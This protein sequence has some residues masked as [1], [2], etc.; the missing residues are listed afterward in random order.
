MS[1]S[2][3][4]EDNRTQSTGSTPDEEKQRQIILKLM[5]DEE[6]PWV[7]P[8]TLEE[9]LPYDSS[10]P[11]IKKRLEELALEN[12]LHERPFNPFA[13]NPSKLYHLDHDNTSWMAPPDAELMS[14]TERRVLDELRDEDGQLPDSRYLDRPYEDIFLDTR[15]GDC[16]Y[17]GHNLF[18]DIT[19]SALAV[20]TI[21]Y[22]AY[23]TAGVLPITQADAGLILLVSIIAALIGCT[24][25]LGTA[26]FGAAKEVVA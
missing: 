3:E 19:L 14:E 23:Q 1:Q 25:I 20:I 18:G 17:Q 26:L 9:R 8:S 15:I 5:E 7:T 11:T 2:G 12:K 24:G 21:S 6:A 16:F 10:R 13:K 4:P 22:I